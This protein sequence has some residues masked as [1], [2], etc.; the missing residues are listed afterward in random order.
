MSASCCE[1]NPPPT[2]SPR[3]RKILWIALLSN[4][5]MFGVE[6]YSG[7]TSG[8][9]S[10]LA[11]SVDFFGDGVNYGISLWVLGM[12]L[13]TRAKASLL[14]AITMAL[15][16]VWI[17]GSAL[18]HAVIGTLPDASTMGAIGLLALLVNVAVAVLLY[19]YRNGDS[20]M[21]SVWLCTR[22]D[23]IGNIVVIIA[24]VGVFGTSSGWPD[25]VVALIMA[26]LALTS[27]WQIIRSA[28]SEL[29]SGSE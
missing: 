2:I 24:A 18:W 19:R 1:H 11:D 17:L 8:S 13:A 12:T 28:R 9:V 14:K 3:Y 7:L 15:F 29:A 6:I 22:N 25:L 10:L 21:R 23:A 20:N 16:G 26:S 27:A 4:F 5:A